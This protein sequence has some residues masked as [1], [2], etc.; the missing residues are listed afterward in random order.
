MIRRRFLHASHARRFRLAQRLYADPPSP[1]AVLAPLATLWEG[2]SRLQIAVRSAAQVALDRPVLSVGGIGLGGSGK[3]PFVRWLASALAREGRSAAVL[4]RGHGWV[5]AHG[6]ALALVPAGT[7]VAGSP[8]SARVPDEA[9]L[10]LRDGLTVGAH[11]RRAAAAA[12]LAR[13]GVRPD[14]WLLD[15]G[16]QHRQLRRDLD[17]V[18]IAARELGATRRG[19][20]AGPFREAWRAL[21]RADRLA[22][23]GLDEGRAGT[24][25][26]VGRRDLGLPP[27]P[28][29][30][31]AGHVWGGSVELE[32]WLAG[33][34][35]DAGGP[36]IGP[37]VAFSGI[38]DPL[39]FERLLLARGLAVRA[40][41][42]FPDHHRYD[43]SDQAR[44]L[45]LLPAGG[46]LLTTEK[47]AARLGSGWAPPGTCR[48]VR[49]ELRLWRGEEDLV[50]DLRRLAGA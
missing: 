12:A 6:P 35:F 23:T 22:I 18:L 39:G 46:T 19:L 4:T 13:V 34:A 32:G 5:D 30:A 27:G 16:F 17:L 43:P 21:R 9:R 8:S 47:D 15:D 36:A 44:L 42:V 10:Y 29:P 48:V 50:E 45:G 38:A 14:V 25:A 31:L 40:H 41:V 3:T 1:P 20:P 28:P 26:G 33:E 11:P 2:A 24:L 37:C 49:A 7:A